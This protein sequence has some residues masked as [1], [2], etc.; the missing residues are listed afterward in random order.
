MRRGLNFLGWVDSQ[1]KLEIV[2]DGVISTHHFSNYNEL[3][4]FSNL[5]EYVDPNEC[6]FLNNL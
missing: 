4:D 6:I 1:I 2:T 5:N 3:M